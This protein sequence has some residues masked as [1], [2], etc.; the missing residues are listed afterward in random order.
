MNLFWQFI[1]LIIAGYINLFFG[2]NIQSAI[3]LHLTSKRKLSI[4]N[5]L[6]LFFTTIP[7][8]MIFIGQNTLTAILFFLLIP[9]IFS[10]NTFYYLI[11]H[12]IVSALYFNDPVSALVSLI[13]SL[14]YKSYVTNIQN[15]INSDEQTNFYSLAK[16][17]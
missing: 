8:D 13:L 9:S 4:C 12:S 15:D 17:Q 6:L 11:W 16:L 10:S 5:L 3:F 1:W 7:F 14:F 2:G